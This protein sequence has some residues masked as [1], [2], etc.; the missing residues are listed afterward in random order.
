MIEERPYSF[1]DYKYEDFDQLSTDHLF[2]FVP[3]GANV[4]RRDGEYWSFAF[5]DFYYSGTT[6]RGAL[7]SW[8][9]HVVEAGTEAM[10]KA[11]A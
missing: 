2:L 11:S 9:R 1:A 6:L 8:L 3:P 4:G 5:G 7:L 10:T